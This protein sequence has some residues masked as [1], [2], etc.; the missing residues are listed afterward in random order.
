MM[1]SEYK[2]MHPLPVLYKTSTEE[3]SGIIAVVY[4]YVGSSISTGNIDL[5]SI[6]FNQA[7]HDT[8]GAGSISST[9]H[10]IMI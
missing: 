7:L 10:G 5:T 6:L 4:K 3:V 1:G 2:A 8:N 9:K